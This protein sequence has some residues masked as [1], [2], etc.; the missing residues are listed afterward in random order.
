[1][2][3]PFY[4]IKCSG[5]SF[6]GS[7]A[8]GGATYIYEGLPEHQPVIQ[9]AWCRDCDNLVKICVPFT[10]KDAQRIDSWTHYIGCEQKKRP[11]Y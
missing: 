3:L 1:M 9:S 6:V 10:R 8:I 2:S 11:S 4:E 7:D 5:C